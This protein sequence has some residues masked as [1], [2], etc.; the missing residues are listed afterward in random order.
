[1]GVANVPPIFGSSTYIVTKDPL[2]SPHQNFDNPA[3]L[4]ILTKLSILLSRV[5]QDLQIDT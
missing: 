5:R 1:M 2:I 3:D 4:Y